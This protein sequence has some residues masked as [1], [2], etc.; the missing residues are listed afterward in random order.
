MNAP[1]KVE[2]TIVWEDSNSGAIRRMRTAR[3]L[4]IEDVEEEEA[5]AE[6]NILRA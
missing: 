5:A 1:E 4:L 2:S 3:S 6:Q